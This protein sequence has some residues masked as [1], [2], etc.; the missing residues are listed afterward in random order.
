MADLPESKLEWHRYR[1]HIYRCRSCK[2]HCQGRGDLE[3]PGAH[4]GPRARLL[5]CYSRA[6]LGISLGKT[7]DLLHDFFGLTI[8]RA[9][10]LGHLRWDGRLFAPVV[11]ELFELLRQS[12]VV[13]GDETGWRINGQTA[14]AWCFR[15]P[16][17]AL[18]LIDR[19]R[20]RD[21]IVRV[22]G[23][24][25]AGT[26]VSDS[27]A[28]Y[29]GLDW[30]KQRCLVHL[31]RELARLREELPWQSVRAFIQPLIELF[32]EAIQLGKDREKLDRAAFGEAYRR[33]IERFD[34]LMLR[35]RSQLPDCVRIWKRLYKHCDELFTLAPSGIF[36]VWRRRGATAARTEPTGVQR[37][38]PGSRA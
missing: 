31:L 6:H 5:T 18:F 22:L 3:L 1:R 17:L 25:F 9:G 15:D 12:P 20:S 33:L 35:T 32:Q 27:Y 4:I 13:Q 28:A 8:G 38:S 16:R 19:H 36:A 23:E 34:D 2:R 30:A 14:W 21:V 7:R 26:L 10:L 29:N 37:R 11:E 24:S